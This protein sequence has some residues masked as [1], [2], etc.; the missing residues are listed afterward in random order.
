[1]RENPQDFFATSDSWVR[2]WATGSGYETG[3]GEFR[4]GHILQF[5]WGPTG[6][7]G[8]PSDGSLSLDRGE[9]IQFHVWTFLYVSAPGTI[10]LTGESDC[11]PR[12]FLNLAFKSPQEFPFGSPASIDL[13][14]DW[15][16]LDITGY[17]QNRG[18]LFESSALAGQVAIMNTSP[19]PEPSTFRILGVF[20]AASGAVVLARR[21]VT[22]RQGSQTFASRGS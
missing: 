21:R 4:G 19:L 1:M 8:N 5:H 22:E 7:V 16:R 17:D 14:A 6:T 15:S 3:W 9:N 13:I 20:L 11:V 12:W 2:S 10:F 18:F